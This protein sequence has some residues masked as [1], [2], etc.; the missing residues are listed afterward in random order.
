MD[1]PDWTMDTVRSN[2]IDVHYYRT[3][4]RDGPPVVLAH[5]YTDDGRCF[6]PLATDL[7]EYD[8]IAPDAR[9]HGRSDAP[10]TGYGID[11]RVAD[12]VG[13]IEALE[14]S[15]PILLGHSMGGTTAAWTAATHP[16]LPRA[17]VLEDP[18]GL[19]DEVHDVDPET[20]A[21]EMATQVRAWQSSSLEEITEEYANRDPDLARILAN[22]RAEC[23]EH[24]A[25]IAREGFPHSSEAFVDITCPT[26]ILKAD[27]DPASRVEHLEVADE[28]EDGRLVHVPDAGHCV[29]RDQYDA[30][31]AELQAF[32]EQI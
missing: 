19:I 29:F 18:A 7:E 5:G 21:E 31:Y 6:A 26:L 16:D 20:R 32:L 12:L 9:G 13:L 15:N 14:L 27:T 22:A 4:T 23:S 1:T 8:V 17:L 11:D 2:G 10:E 28:L 3:G 30:A 25:E 24:I